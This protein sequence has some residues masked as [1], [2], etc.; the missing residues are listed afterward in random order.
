MKILILSRNITKS[1]QV[2][3]ET[4]LTI[5]L[6]LEI[7]SLV[8]VL[9]RFQLERYSSLSFVMTLMF[10]IYLMPNTFLSTLDL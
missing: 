2:N 8:L 5:L 3:N 4:M 6:C 7:C 10:N 1:Y 9:L